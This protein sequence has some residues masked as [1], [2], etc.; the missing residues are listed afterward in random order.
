ML[1]LGEPFTQKEVSEA[2][3]AEFTA[4]H[5]FFTTLAEDDFFAAPPNVWSPADNLYQSCG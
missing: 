5:S 3:T 1:K 2:L 4:V